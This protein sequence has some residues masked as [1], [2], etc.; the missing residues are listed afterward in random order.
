MFSTHNSLNH[1]RT[2]RD[3]DQENQYQIKETGITNNLKNNMNSGLSHQRPL[4]LH[5]PQKGHHHSS[6]SSSSSSIQKKGRRALGDISNKVNQNNNTININNKTP[7]NSN[8]NNKEPL[9]NKIKGLSSRKLAATTSSSSSG[10]R[11]HK[12]MKESSHIKDRKDLVHSFENDSSYEIESCL[13]RGYKEEEMVLETLR[14]N[15]L[16]EQMEKELQDFHTAHV[17]LLQQKKKGLSSM[18]NNNIIKEFKEIN[19]FGD[20]SSEISGVDDYEWNAEQDMD[21]GGVIN[22]LGLEDED[23]LL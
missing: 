4:G 11:N 16:N 20:Q 15:R 21:L 5:V 14:K 12:M 13:G 2:N 9:K 7:G 19:V 17:Q 23:F 8:T 10:E 3:S 22:E 6:S 1:A 18:N